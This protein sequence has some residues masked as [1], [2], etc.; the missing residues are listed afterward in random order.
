MRKNCYFHKINEQVFHFYI[1][2]ENLNIVV[3]EIEFGD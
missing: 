1:F 2:V 3:G